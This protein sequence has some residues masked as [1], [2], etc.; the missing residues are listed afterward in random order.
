MEKT[1]KG[2]YVK[3]TKNRYGTPKYR[4]QRHECQKQTASRLQLTMDACR[5][6]FEIFFHF[7]FFR[8]ILIAVILLKNMG[9]EKFL[10]WKIFLLV[11]LGQI[12]REKCVFMSKSIFSYLSLESSWN[13]I[14][15][16]QI[17]E[18]VRIFFF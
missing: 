17:I 2:E 16:L 8:R 15:L 6:S 13:I 14:I 12:Y 11:F 7:F 3:P 1:K 4:W 9:G 5:Y 10:F 18:D